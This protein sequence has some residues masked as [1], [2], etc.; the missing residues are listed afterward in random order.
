MNVQPPGHPADTL[1]ALTGVGVARDGRWLVRNVDLE[2]RRGEIV[3]LIG[4]NGS[5][6]S[7]V[8]KAAL[9]VHAP[10]EGRVLRDASLRVGYVPQRMAIDPTLPLTVDRL[11]RLTGPLSADE[12]RAALELVGIPQLAQAEVHRLSGGEFQRALLARAIARRP[13]LLV[14]D[15]PLQ[16]VDFTGEVALYELI[17]RIRAETGCGILLVSHDLHV[18]M[19]QTDT[20]VCLNGHVCCRGT[21]QSVSRSP[22]YLALFGARAA[23]TLAIYSHHHDHTHLADGRVRHADG[24]ITDGDEHQPE[25]PHGHDHHAGHDDAR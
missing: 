18:V 6:K 23:S 21:P 15:E 20:V 2:V 12:R 14:L 25:H 5:G 16:G 22:E 11:L 13:D 1:V 10:D 9:G 4:P 8:A 17:V 3:T 19:A 24:S 7:T